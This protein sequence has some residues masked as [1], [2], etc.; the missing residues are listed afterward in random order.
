SE[1]EPAEIEGC[2]EQQE[3]D[4][5]DQPEL[6]E[7]LSSGSSAKV[8]ANARKEVGPGP[9]SRADRGDG[10]SH[11]S[12]RVVHDKPRCSAGH[13]SRSLDLVQRGIARNV[14]RGR[15]MVRPRSLSV[16]ARSATEDHRMS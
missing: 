8:R 3:E 1:R 14:F 6:D 16:A 15:T 11:A 4:G 2:R 13:L 10:V 12:T 9:I 5:Q 7:A